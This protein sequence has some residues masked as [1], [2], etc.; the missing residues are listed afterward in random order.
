MGIS[1]DGCE[2]THDMIRKKRGAFKLALKGIRNCLDVGVKTGLRFTLMKENFDDLG[3]D[4][5]N[6]DE[7][8]KQV[9]VLDTK[10]IGYFIYTVFN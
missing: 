10:N 7:E 8:N 2:K 5:V 1:I 3:I 4:A 9:L 6:I